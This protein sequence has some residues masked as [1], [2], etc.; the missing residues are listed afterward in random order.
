VIT[1]LSLLAMEGH[2]QPANGWLSPKL[3][4]RRQ[5]PRGAY[6]LHLDVK[7][8]AHSFFRNCGSGFLQLNTASEIVADV[9]VA[10]VSFLLSSGS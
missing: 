6:K 10:G 9:L 7:L 4:C 1:V 5:P 2:L 3:Q 8:H